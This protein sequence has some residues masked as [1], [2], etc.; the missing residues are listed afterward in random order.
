MPI[1]FLDTKPCDTGMYVDFDAEG[2]CK[3]CPINTYQIKDVSAI[4]CRDCPAD[5]YT[6]SDKRVGAKESDVCKRTFSFVNGITSSILFHSFVQGDG[7]SAIHL[8]CMQYQQS[9]N[10]FPFFYNM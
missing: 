2:T 9:L 4:L 7:K 1:I 6:N 8:I 3:L 5:T 10:L